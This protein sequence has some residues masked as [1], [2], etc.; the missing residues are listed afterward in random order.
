MAKIMPIV[1]AA[2][3]SS[4]MGGFPKALLPLGQNTFLGHI[5]DVLRA[6]GLSGCHLVLGSQAQEIRPVAAAHNARITVNPQPERGQFSSLRLALDPLDAAC[7]GCLVW[8]VDQPW[9]SPGLVRSLVVLFES[10]AAQLALPRRHGASGHPA[11]FGRRL[12]EDL[13]AA[14]PE[15]NPKDIIG[16]YRAAA[17]WL[18]T[19]ETGAFEDIDTPEDYFRLTGE[20]LADAIR[21]SAIMRD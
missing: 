14:P 7:D 11:I 4:R 17:A 21:R 18:E 19:E 15:A 10:S 13:L 12:I 9:I 16:P 20:T 8:P 6:A 1:L 3:D 5:L 2:G